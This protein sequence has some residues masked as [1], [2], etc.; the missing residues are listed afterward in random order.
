MKVTSTEQFV[1]TIGVNPGYVPDHSWAT[2]DSV[3]RA[4]IPTWYRLMTVEGD[5]SGVYPSAV[6]H[7]GVAVYRNEANGH[8]EPIAVAIGTC[9]PKYAPDF[10]VWRLSVL[11]VVGELKRILKQ[12]TCQLAFSEVRMVYF[13][14]GD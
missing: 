10:D 13:E 12:V 1:L 5:R 11:R 4:V 3:M 14:E 2:H 7:S 8:G 6:F 9:N